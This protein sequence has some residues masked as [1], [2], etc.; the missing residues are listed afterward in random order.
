MTSVHYRVVR[1]SVS[2]S[3]SDESVED[4]IFQSLPRTRVVSAELAGEP[5]I[6]AR[7]RLIPEIV[8]AAIEAVGDPPAA[9][10]VADRALAILHRFYTR[11]E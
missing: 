1:F 11:D 4:R 6:E 5:D 9:D 10:C 8:A 2:A 7:R 3:S